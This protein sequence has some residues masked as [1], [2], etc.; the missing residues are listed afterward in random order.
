VSAAAEVGARVSDYL[1]FGDTRAGSLGAAEPYDFFAALLVCVVVG[2][3]VGRPV[4]WQIAAGRSTIGG[5]LAAF[6]IADHAGSVRLTLADAANQL[7]GLASDV[8]ARL[9]NRG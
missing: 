4:M 6:A 5:N 8:T 7:M 9:G 2:A 1:T 3:A